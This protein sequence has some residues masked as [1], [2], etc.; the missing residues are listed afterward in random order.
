MAEIAE[1]S[2]AQ[3][4]SNQVLGSMKATFD[5]ATKGGD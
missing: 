1:A 2:D 3:W 5:I 4:E